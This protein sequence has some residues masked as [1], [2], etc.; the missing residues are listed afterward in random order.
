MVLVLSIH[1]P[2]ARGGAARGVAVTLT[3][4]PPPKRAVP[5]FLRWV[6]GSTPKGSTVL[7]VGG[8]CDHSGEPMRVRRRAGRLVVVDPSERVEENTSADE[9]HCM[10][11]EEF[12]ADHEDEFDLAFAVFV[13][14]HVRDP[15]AF[16]QAAARVLRPGGT[17]MAITVNQWHYFGLP[18]WAAT[19]LGAADAVLRRVRGPE[20]AEYHVPTEYR[21]NTVRSTVRHLSDAGFSSVELRT[22]DLPSMYEPYLPRP[23]RGIATGWNRMAYRLDNPHLMGHLTFKAVL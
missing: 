4:T 18:A 5:G 15:A 1:G 13:L 7:N 19:R 14:E 22:W 11:L 12:A 20:V 6:A 23:L 16:T 8:G 17:L 3:A 2:S 10:T 21:M 9:Q